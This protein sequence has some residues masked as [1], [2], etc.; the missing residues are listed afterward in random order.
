MQHLSISLT[1][2]MHLKLMSSISL[3]VLLFSGLT[4][5]VPS[6]SI[7]RQS[8]GVSMNDVCFDVQLIGST[9]HAKCVSDKALPEF[10]DKDLNLCLVNNHGALN[11]DSRCSWHRCTFL[12]SISY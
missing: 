10:T 9:I 2:T 7:R 3:L 6:P 12:K 1:L 4:K 11:F 5:A 8:D